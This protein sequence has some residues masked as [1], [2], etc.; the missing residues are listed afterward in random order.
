M[1]ATARILS[2]SLW[3]NLRAQKRNKNTS[4]VPPQSE[5]V[6]AQAFCAL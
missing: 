4:S 5:F 1:R 2:T 3:M 6:G